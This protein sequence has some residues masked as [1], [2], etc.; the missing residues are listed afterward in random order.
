MSCNRDEFLKLLFVDDNR[1]LA[2]VTFHIGKSMPYFIDL[3]VF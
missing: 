1:D 2:L 3:K